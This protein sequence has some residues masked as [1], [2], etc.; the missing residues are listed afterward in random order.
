[1]RIQDFARAEVSARAIAA[2]ALVTAFALVA[3]PAPQARAAC[4]TTGI[5]QTCTNP[6]GTT[7]SAGTIGIGDSD[8]LNLTNFGTVTGTDTGVSANN[9]ANVFNAG[10]INGGGTGGIFANGTAN[11]TNTAGGTITGGAY[12]IYSNTDINLTN[13]GTINGIYGLY[14]NGDVSATN[15]GTI[16]GGAFGIF[17]NGSANV[18]NT[19]TIS[20]ASD[21]IVAVGDLT[22]NNA[23]TVTSPSGIAAASANGT[24]NVTNS[25]TLAGAYGV[26]GNSVNVTNSGTISGDFNGV[27]TI[28]L[29]PSTLVNSGTII[30]TSGAAIDFSFSAFDTLT[31][32]PGSRVIGEILLGS[33]DTVNIVTGRQVSTVLSFGCS[34]GQYG[35][36]QTGSTLNVSGGAPYVYIPGSGTHDVFISIDPTALSIAD[37]SLMN[38]TGFISSLLGNRFGEFGFSGTTPSAFAAPAVNGIVEGANAAFSSLAYA[39]DRIPNAVAYDRAS[40]FSVWSKGFAGVRSQG[41]DGP[42]LGSTSV[43]FGG[44]MGLDKMVSSD[45]RLGAFIGAGNGKLQVDLNSQT[46]KTD[47]LFGGVYGRYDWTTQFMDFAV[48]GGQTSNKSDRT[49]F[50]NLLPGGIETASASYNGWFVTPELAYGMRIP[51]GGNI[52][53]TPAARLRYLAAYFGGYDESGST[54]NLSVGSRMAQNVEERLEVAFS[55]MDPLNQGML[56]STATLG[57]LGQE[58]LGSTAI[59]AIVAG[60]NLS[61]AATGQNNVA[62]AYVSLGFD[63]KLS[64]SVSIFSS[65]EMTV[66]SDDTLTGLAQGGLRITLN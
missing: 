48:S 61:F 55:R 18:I 5:D 35:I 57:V 21:G 6:A 1:M 39:D 4:S 37:K 22:L 52:V 62:G 50:N 2:L 51:M 40:G 65:A 28:G 42:N 13:A 11:I 63:Y 64:R 14:A 29:S 47:Y 9:D 24:A 7:V 8:T 34:C 30:G 53:M 49:I 17:A 66:T 45:L 27:L 26:Y 54:Q 12:G 46:V 15:S 23:G 20:S 19:G 33:P 43:A 60:Q 32:L 16:T 25:G 58:R 44:V 41:T 38:F 31:F 36:T 10:T 3:L 56:K 59:S